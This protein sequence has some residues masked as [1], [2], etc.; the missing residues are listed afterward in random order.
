M[1]IHPSNRQ[2]KSEE[3]RKILLKSALDLFGRYGY[4]AVTVDDI[5]KNV[6]MSKGSFYNLFRSKSDLVIYRSEV[7]GEDTLTEYER[8]SKQPGYAEKNAV[9]KIRDLI[10]ITIAI[11]TASSNQPFL[12]QMFI[13]VMSDPP[14]DARNFFE[15]HQTDDIVRQ[16]IL[17]GQLNGEIRKD[18]DCDEI[19][20]AIH[21]FRR[22][23]LLEW[24]YKKGKHDI[25]ER[26]RD[27]ID[28]FC[29]GIA[30][31]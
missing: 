20:R 22:Y 1:A 24:C 21:V 2:R 14:E 17:K 13:S 28:I 12:S 16:T 27:A 23:L 4:N 19:L 8:L 15:Q 30:Q 29:A 26:N 3:N 11:S 18:I 10:T 6:G 31:H 5:V 7:L 25:V 9:E